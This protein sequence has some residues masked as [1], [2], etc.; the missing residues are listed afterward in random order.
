ME[1]QRS[2]PSD[3]PSSQSLD[4]EDGADNKDK[5]VKAG[6]VPAHTD[7][8]FQVRSFSYGFLVNKLDEMSEDSLLQRGGGDQGDVAAMELAA[9]R[10]TASCKS[11]GGGG[12]Y[13]RQ[14]LSSILISI[15]DLV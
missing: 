11:R 10:T 4:M 5:A 1:L 15:L 6:F 7:Q 2:S 9:I 3:A 13:I 14:R 12:V 8:P